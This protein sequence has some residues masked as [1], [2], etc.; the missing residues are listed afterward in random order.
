MVTTPLAQLGKMQVILIQ[1]LVAV[2]EAQWERQEEMGT[3]E[4]LVENQIGRMM[5]AAAVAAAADM[6]A[7]AAGEDMVTQEKLELAALVLLA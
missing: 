1:T 5:A 2:T 4:V 6:V 3:L 7:V